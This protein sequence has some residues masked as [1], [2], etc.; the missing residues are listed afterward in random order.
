[1]VLAAN[2]LTT[3]SA[4]K[5]ELDISVPDDDAYIESLIDA[6]STQIET[7]LQRHLLQEIGRVERV[8]GYG[9]YTLILSLT[10]VTVLTSIE[11]I[12]MTAPPLFPFDITDVEIKD[13]DAGLVYYRAGWPW[14]VP[15]PYG[16]ITADPM[17]GQEWNVIEVTYDG[18]YLLPDDPTP[19]LPVDIQRA[20]TIAVSTE[21]RKRGIDRTIKSE[22]LMSYSITYD[23]TGM[24]EAT[25]HKLYPASPFSAQVTQMLVP[26][27]HIPGA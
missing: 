17:P 12:S 14:T 8:S 24:G 23:R 5:L 20:C 15:R 26:H 2:A 3:L 6:V 21:F 1:M 16:T 22:R 10:P 18:G 7:F 4:V 27:R 13:A 9:N 25:M 11:I 19:T